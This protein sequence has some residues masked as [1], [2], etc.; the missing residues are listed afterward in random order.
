MQRS[1]VCDRGTGVDLVDCNDLRGRGGGREAELGY[2]QCKTK[3][4]ILDEVHTEM[5]VGEK[6]KTEVRL[7]ELFV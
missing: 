6:N 7:L 4:I 3:K 2:G 1:F 5:K